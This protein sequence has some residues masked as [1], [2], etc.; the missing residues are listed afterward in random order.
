MPTLVSLL[1]FLEK[2][3]VCLYT[4]VHKAAKSEGYK[5]V[6]CEMALVLSMVYCIF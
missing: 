3:E 5:K 1:Y 6:Y 4:S 2:K